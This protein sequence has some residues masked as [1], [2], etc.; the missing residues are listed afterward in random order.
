MEDV[1]VKKEKK[2]KQIQACLKSEDDSKESLTD[3]LP[4]MANRLSEHRKMNTDDDNFD[5][6]LLSEVSNSSQ[7]DLDEIEKKI[8]SV[9]SRLGL[10]VESDEEIKPLYLKSEKGILKV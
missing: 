1:K 10:L 2:I 7:N 8:R 4:V 3:N 5:I 6:P 9:K